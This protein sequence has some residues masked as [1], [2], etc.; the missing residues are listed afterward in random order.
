MTDT[1]RNTASCVPSV[2]DAWFFYATRHNKEKLLTRAAKKVLE[3]PGIDFEELLKLL[4]VKMGSTSAHF[5]VNY[6]YHTWEHRGAGAVQSIA[7]RG[8]LLALWYF[9]E[10]KR[11]ESQAS[12]SCISEFYLSHDDVLMYM[13]SHQDEP[14]T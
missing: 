1:V 10:V 13:C 4:R 7:P 5:V 8:V 14:R 9:G 2:G 3:V 6:L 12:M 11:L